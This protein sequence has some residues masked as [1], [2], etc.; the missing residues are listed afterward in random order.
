[1]EFTLNGRLMR[2]HVTR[3][4]PF[5]HP[6]NGEVSS[7]E[8]DMPAPEGLSGAPLILVGGYEVVGVIYHSHTVH[9]VAEL[10]TP[11]SFGLAQVTPALRSL[12]ARATNELSLE[13]Y[14]HQDNG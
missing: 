12:R 9:A 10:E 7:Y 5:Q 8:L 3:T 13:T 6:K 2:G 14:T 11:V 4:F 1:M